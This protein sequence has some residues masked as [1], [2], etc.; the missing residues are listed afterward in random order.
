MTYLETA[1]FS[2]NPYQ[3]TCHLY[4]FQLWL[5]QTLVTVA[6]LEDRDFY[7]CA[8]PEGLKDRYILSVNPDLTPCQQHKSHLLVSLR[9]VLKVLAAA[10]I[11]VCVIFVAVCLICYY[12][13]ICSQVRTLRYKWQVRY[14]EVSARAADSAVD[15]L[16]TCDDE[17]SGNSF[18]QIE[19]ADNAVLTLKNDYTEDVEIYVK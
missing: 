13:R 4:P 15:T 6:H 12:T 3:C 2:R 9:F 14:R 10:F 1:D 18:E 11:C 19:V 16:E 5:N 8:S 17:H 7:Q